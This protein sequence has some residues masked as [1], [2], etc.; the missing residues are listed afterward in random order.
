MK[1]IELAYF[2]DNVQAMAGFYRAMYRGLF[3]IQLRMIESFHARRVQLHGRRLEGKPRGE[4][5]RSPE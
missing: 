3:F 2:T 4:V 1:L 5:I